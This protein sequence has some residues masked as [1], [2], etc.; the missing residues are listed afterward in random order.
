MA[1]E[2]YNQDMKYHGGVITNIITLMDRG[3]PLMGHMSAARAG[4]VQNLSK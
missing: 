1:K 4:G 3:F 2:V